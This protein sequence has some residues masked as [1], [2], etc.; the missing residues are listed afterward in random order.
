MTELVLAEPDRARFVDLG[1]ARLRAWE[2]GDQADPVV[3]CLHGA[4]DHGRMFDALAPRVADLGYNVVALDLRGHGD[5]ERVRSGHVWESS[6]LDVARAARHYGAPV[7]LV[8]HSFG[9]GQAL[10][11]ALSFP[12]L[13]RW[14]VNIDGLGPPA[15]AFEDERDVAAAAAA[16]IASAER[17]FSLP[18]RTYAT[19]EEMVERRGQVNVRLPSAWLDHLV[20]HGSAETGD[21]FVWKSDPVFSIGFPGDFN[22]EYLQAEHALVRCPVLAITG[23]ERDTWSELNPEELAERLRPIADV[24]HHVVR[25]AGHYVHVE[26]PDA[27]FELIAE[28]VSE[29]ERG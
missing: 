11:V 3:L 4:Y 24:R 16:A 27:T 13:V 26:Q 14:V 15:E 2:W 20:V 8:G 21:G 7:G 28:F 1:G 9:G 22:I 5:S 10:T 25:D 19:Q 23:G 12:E 18:P 6:A 29:V 17:I